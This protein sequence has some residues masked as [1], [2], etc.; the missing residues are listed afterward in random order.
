MRHGDGGLLAHRRQVALHAREGDPGLEL[1]QVLCHLLVC[2][3]PVLQL[4]CG[5]L[6]PALRDPKLAGGP[7][8][9]TVER[10]YG[11]TGRGHH[12]AQAVDLVAPELGAH[13]R[14]HP[15]AEDVHAV[16]VDAEAARPIELLEVLVAAL[17]QG[18]GQLL[19]LQQLT[20]GAVDHAAA[21]GDYQGRE[22]AAARRRDAAQEGACARAHH[23]G[24]ASRQQADGA[25]ALA[26]GL[27]IHSGIG[28]GQVSALWQHQH[29]LAP[30]EG[31]HAVGKALG[32]LL[33][34]HHHQRG[35]RAARKSAGHEEGA[36]RCHQPDAGVFT[37]LELGGGRCQRRAL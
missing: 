37:C 34:A 27:V 10:A 4:A 25:G 6:G 1:G 21:H 8:L 31:R 36:H 20:R 24:A 33:P 14:R 5:A 13:R 29:L 35:A 26:Q 18:A 28:P 7:D 23:H 9:H 17:Q 2:R 19:V 12:A 22:K 3:R 32:G 11:L 15:R 16:A 30:D